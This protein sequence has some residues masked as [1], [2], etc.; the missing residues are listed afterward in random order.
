MLDLCLDQFLDLMMIMIVGLF[1]IAWVDLV[2]TLVGIIV[3]IMIQINFFEYNIP[4]TKMDCYIPIFLPLGM[5]CSGHC[6]CIRWI[7][8]KWIK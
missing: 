3:Q 8:V 7:D 2:E 6:D 1:L 4:S 5:I